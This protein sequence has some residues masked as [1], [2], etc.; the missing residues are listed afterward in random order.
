MHVH[1][2]T[3]IHFVCAYLP[4]CLPKCWYGVRHGPWAADDDDAAPATVRRGRHFVDEEADEESESGDDDEDE[5]MEDADED[6]DEDGE[7]G[8]EDEDEDGIPEFDE[9]GSD[10][11]I[12]EAGEALLPP[13]MMWPRVGGMSR[14]AHGALALAQWWWWWCSRCCVWRWMRCAQSTNVL[15]LSS[16]VRVRSMPARPAPCTCMS[17]GTQGR[18]KSSRR[19]RLVS[20]CCLPRKELP[21]AR[22][23]TM[24]PEVA[25]SRARA[26]LLPLPLPL[27]LQPRTRTRMKR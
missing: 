16:G 7:D 21:R 24:P 22:P 3:C 19:R 11:L 15:L 5:E 18:G 25:K 13:W 14:A 1:A 4:T 23:A 26:V 2:R 17:C 8:E 10:D 9:L 27:P 6:E 12:A 20:A